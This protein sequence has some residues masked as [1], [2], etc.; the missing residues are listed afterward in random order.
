MIAY[1][2]NIQISLEQPLNDHHVR[3]FIRFHNHPW[4]YY[5]DEDNR[6][7]CKTPI[8]KQYRGITIYT[9]DEI[10]YRMYCINGGYVGQADGHRSM[11]SFNNTWIRFYGIVQ[12]ADLIKKVLLTVRKRNGGATTGLPNPNR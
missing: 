2:A 1:D 3:D 10:E 4:Q 8:V 7:V 6:A 12:P 5:C 9:A 11:L